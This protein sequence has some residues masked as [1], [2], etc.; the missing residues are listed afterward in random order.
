MEGQFH[1]VMDCSVF[2]V[3]LKY[4]HLVFKRIGKI[5]Q[6]MILGYNNNGILFC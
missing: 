4:R 5:D 1:T 6:R 2:S 3:M